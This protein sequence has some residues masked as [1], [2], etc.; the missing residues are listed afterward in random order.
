MRR[1]MEGLEAGCHADIGGWTV[2]R[3]GWLVRNHMDKWVESR[4]GSL[5]G[6]QTS[7]DE[8]VDKLASQPGGEWVSPCKQARG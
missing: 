3:T 7:R 1:Q 8:Q 4:Q 6:Q 5:A 2:E